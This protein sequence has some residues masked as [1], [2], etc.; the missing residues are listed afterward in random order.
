MGCPKGQ[1]ASHHNSESERI[2]SRIDFDEVYDGLLELRDAELNDI[3]DRAV[4]NLL[5]YSIDKLTANKRSFGGHDAKA[6]CESVN[7][8]RDIVVKS[9]ERLITKALDESRYEVVFQEADAL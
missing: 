5:V 8:I 2:T 7:I 3:A 4:F 1:K 9:R 6:I